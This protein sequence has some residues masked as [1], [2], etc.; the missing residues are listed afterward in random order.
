MYEVDDSQDEFSF[1]SRHPLAIWEQLAAFVI[2]ILSEL[3]GWAVTTS[4]G[5]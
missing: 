1:A 3:N 5:E 2:D 4:K